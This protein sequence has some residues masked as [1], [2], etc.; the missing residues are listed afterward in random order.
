MMERIAELARIARDDYGVRAS[1]HAHAGC[2]VEFEDE[3]DRAMDDLPPDLVGLCVDTGHSAYAGIDPVALIRRYGS[4]VGHMHLKDIDPDVRAACLAE[5]TD[6]FSA[7]ARGIFCPLGRG[8]VDFPGVRDA[9]ADIGYGGLLVIEQD[10]DPT[11][12]ASPLDNARES[13]RYLASVGLAPAEK[14]PAS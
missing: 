13:Y 9:L 6:F 5:E 10:V 14:L 11:G 8:V 2:Y 3:I 4:R 7:V 1:L 12:D